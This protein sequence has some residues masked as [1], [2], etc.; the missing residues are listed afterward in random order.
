M[1]LYM[2]IAVAAADDTQ[3]TNANSSPPITY[4]IDSPNAPSVTKVFYFF[5]A[6]RQFGAAPGS[7]GG[8]YIGDY[9]QT[10]T[11]NIVFLDFAGISVP[12]DI[13]P[14]KRWKNGSNDCEASQMKTRIMVVCGPAAKRMT[15]SIF[16]YEF[17]RGVT[18]FFEH[19]FIDRTCWFEL[20]TNKGLL[21]NLPGAK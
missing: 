11:D 7:E 20:E 15:S 5:E 9:S 3:L 1:L 13:A 19:C 14:G 2:L 21:A 10:I 6:S 18:G 4:R 17:G 12:L 16:E 8:T